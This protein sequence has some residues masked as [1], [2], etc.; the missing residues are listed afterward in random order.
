[1]S[2]DLTES[3]CN[4]NRNKVHNKCDALELSPNPSHLQFMEKLSSTSPFSGA[5]TVGDCCMTL[6]DMWKMY[7]FWKQNNMKIFIS[8]LDGW[9]H[10]KRRLVYLL[11]VTRPSEQLHLACHKG[12]WPVEWMSK[13]WGII[14]IYIGFR[15]STGTQCDYFSFSLF[16]LIPFLY[17]LLIENYLYE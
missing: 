16:F 8:H 11:E 5:K 10:Q 3:W 13:S 1:M 17:N 9:I 7:H 14:N 6:T 12:N 4:S 2:D 15:E